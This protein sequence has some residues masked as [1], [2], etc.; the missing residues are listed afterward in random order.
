M[1]VTARKEAE[2]Q[3]L[4][5]VM[6]FGTCLPMR[7]VYQRFSRY[8]KAVKAKP[9]AVLPGYLFVGMSLD[10]P[11]WIDMMSISTGHSAVG[12]DGSQQYQVK[13]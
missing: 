12:F 3:T 13:H 10:T 6:G 11:G 2:A 8:R 9:Y 4:L 5:R 1:R 7:R